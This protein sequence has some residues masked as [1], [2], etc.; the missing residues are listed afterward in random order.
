MGVVT[1]VTVTSHRR[2]QHA[3]GRAAT[4][5]EY[6]CKSVHEDVAGIDQGRCQAL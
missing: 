2:E 3:Y 6:L 5:Y 4:E 1:P